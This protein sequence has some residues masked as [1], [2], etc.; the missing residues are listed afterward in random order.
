MVPWSK[1]L[2][3]RAEVKY[4]PPTN[5]PIML[6]KPNRAGVPIYGQPRDTVV[7]MPPP[8]AP[9][10]PPPTPRPPVPPISVVYHNAEQT[11]VNTCPEGTTG[12]PISV[13]IP[14]NYAP[15]DSEVSQEAANACAL[16][17]ACAEAAALRELNPCVESNPQSLWGWGRNLSYQLGMGDSASR[18]T[19]T[20]IGTEAE[21]AWVKVSGGSTYSIGLKSDGTLWS[22]GSNFNGE[23]GNGQINSVDGTAANRL[24]PSQ[25]GSDTWLDI[26][27]SFVNSYGIKSD[28]TLWSWG[29]N[30]DGQLGQGDTTDRLVPTQIGSASNWVQVAAG[31]LT[32][33]VLNSEGEI[34]SCGKAQLGDGSSGDSDVLVLVGGG[35]SFVVCGGQHTIAIKSD[36]TMWGW[37]R[38]P[39]IGVVAS[40]APVQIESDS[41]WESVSA[42]WNYTIGKKLDGTLW[43]MGSNDG[44]QLGLG[45]LVDRTVFTQIGSD[46]DWSDTATENTSTSGGHTIAIKSDGTIWG[47]G[48]NAVGQIGQGIVGSPVLSPTAI[49]PDDLWTGVGSGQNFSFGFRSTITPPPPPPN[50]SSVAIGGTLSIVGLYTIHRFDLDGT[51]TVVDGAGVLFDVLRV[52]GG[53]GGAAGGG[54]AGRFIKETG[55]S[56]ADGVYPVVVGG[57]GLAQ[58]SGNDG[59]DGTS[60]TFNGQTA[61]GGGGGGGYDATAGFVNGRAGASGGGGGGFALSLLVGT[62]GVASAGNNGGDASRTEPTGPNGGFGGGGGGG[63]GGAPGAASSSGTTGVGG[64]GGAGT[65]DSITGTAVFYAAGGGGVGTST[66]GAGGSSVGG[67]GSTSATIPAT[68]GLTP[69]SGGGGDRGLGG[70]NGMRGVVIIRYLTPP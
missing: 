34:W 21:L 6:L 3:G 42:G 35:Y 19:P 14:A 65:S 28:G 13:T 64:A 32:L 5:G 25:V 11:C 33:R 45:D 60:T 40:L 67:S 61:P 66:A 43:G 7:F 49:G 54:G 10:P 70:G 53:A 2:S 57:G 1:R 17:A 15:C 48:S 59:D 22:W 58:G 39:P 36:N 12:E 46:S 29:N 4:F 20:L 31:R 23:L 62:G 9:L 30:Q 52:G 26:S 38:L 18:L 56:M 16:A 51:F 68:V 37:G 44:G 41:D 69:G 27:A 63:S 50:T 24:F 47:W 8:V 55:V